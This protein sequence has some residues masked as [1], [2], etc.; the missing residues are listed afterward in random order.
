MTILLLGLL[1]AFAEQSIDAK[2]PDCQEVRMP[3]RDLRWTLVSNPNPLFCPG[4][5]Q[6]NGQKTII[7][8][9]LINEQTHHKELVLN[10]GTGGD[11]GWAP[12]S[13]AFFVNYR[14]G[15]NLGDASLYRTD[16]LK[17][18]DLT[19]AI[20]KKDPTV[21]KYMDG[22]RYVFVRKW[23]SNDKALVQFCGH[24]DRNP[25]V[26]FDI[27]YRIDLNGVI[28]RLSQKQNP[29]GEVGDCAWD[30]SDAKAQ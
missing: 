9:S 2:F 11:A 28:D 26:Q 23:L 30:D 16:P 7:E 8:L 13:T 10:Q 21:R 14:I 18:L 17:R 25:V 20:S 4:A 6:A 15:S 5:K 3:S 1:F 19:E 12:D 27:R 24:T 29:P 22:H